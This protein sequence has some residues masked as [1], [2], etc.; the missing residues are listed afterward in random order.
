[1]NKLP[2]VSIKLISTHRLDKEKGRDLI[3]AWLN[4]PT[5]QQLLTGNGELQ[6]EYDIYGD[7]TMR[8]EVEKLVQDYPDR[9]RYHG[10]IPLQ[11]ILS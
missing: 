5:G 2:G 4:S 3:I 8:S 7:G 11:T 1:M 10:F 6:I 9:I